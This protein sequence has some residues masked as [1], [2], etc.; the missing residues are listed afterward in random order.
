ME[1]WGAYRTQKK[2]RQNYFK[3]KKV[4]SRVLSFTCTNWAEGRKGHIKL[5]LIKQKFKECHL[6]S[7]TV[8]DFRED[9]IKRRESKRKGDYL[10]HSKTMLGKLYITIIIV[11]CQSSVNNFGTFQPAS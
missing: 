7:V 9:W 6:T 1:F 5:D 2:T 8:I 3:K 11:T 10:R 4:H